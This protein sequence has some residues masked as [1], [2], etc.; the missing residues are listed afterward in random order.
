[1]NANI[2]QAFLSSWGYFLLDVS[3]CEVDCSEIKIHKL[4]VELQSELMFSKTISLFYW[5]FCFDGLF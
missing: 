3:F 4:Y 5:I 2:T 1:M